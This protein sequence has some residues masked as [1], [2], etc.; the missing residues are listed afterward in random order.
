MA[1]KCTRLANGN[2][3]VETPATMF[4]FNSYNKDIYTNGDDVIISAVGHILI[5]SDYTHFTTAD[6]VT[7]LGVTSALTAVNLMTNYFSI[8]TP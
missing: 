2:V 4:G 6:G 7:A 8:T 3:K 1:I 5:K